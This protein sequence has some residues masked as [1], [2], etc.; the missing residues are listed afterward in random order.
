MENPLKNG[1]GMKYPDIWKTPD[2]FSSVGKARVESL[3]DIVEEIETLIKERQ[4][5]SGEFIKEGE[6]MK[7]DIN[8]FLLESAPKGEDDS[9]FARERAELRKKQIEISE[10]Q[11]NEKIGCWRDIALLKKELRDRTRELT[12]KES[13]SEEIKRILGE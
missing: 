5:L 1:I 10:I 3:K 4:N 6:K 11:L 12:E 2:D 9:E 7:R 8:N 13:R